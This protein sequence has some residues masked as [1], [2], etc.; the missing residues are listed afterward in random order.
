MYANAYGMSDLDLAVPNSVDTVFNLA[1]VSKQFTAFAIA[2]LEKEGKLELQ[3]DIRRY[4]PNMPE[5]DVP[6]TVADLVHHTSGLRDYITLGVLGGHDDESLIRQE[7]AVQIMERQNGVEFAAGTAYSYSNTGYVLLAEIVKAA[8]G[9]PFDD[10]MQ[11]RVFAPLGMT[12]TRVRHDLADL[13]PGYATGYMPD[14]SDNKWRRAVYNRIALGPGNVLSTVGDLAKWAGNF[15]NPRVGNSDL[16]DRLSAPARLRDGNSVNYGYGLRRE[17]IAGHN[18]VAH[19]GGIAGFNTDFAYF[20][21]LDFAVIVLANRPFPAREVAT[22]VAAIYL[23]SEESSLRGKVPDWR[24]TPKKPL[25]DLAGRYATKDGPVLTLE[26][27]QGSFRVKRLGRD[28]QQLRFWSDDSISTGQYDGVRY[29]LVTGSDGNITALETVGLSNSVNSSRQAEYLSRIEPPGTP[30]QSLLA[31]TGNYRSDE[32]DATYRLTVES[33][34]VS[35]RSLWMVGPQRMV[36]TASGRFEAETGPLQGLRF[37]AEYDSNGEC[38]ALIFR[39][40]RNGA[41]RLNRTSI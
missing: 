26:P 20:P 24:A 6:V 16:I 23:S 30:I 19:G 38:A 2:L 29:R 7:H 35:L 8:S 21:E 39:Y 5:Q 3:H 25:P 37:T 28:P 13:Q 31:L 4:L 17:T 9:I 40:G 36:E 1:S 14:D 32:I 11:Q 22:E 33:G 27:W 15:T 12:H 10:F 18:A 34:Q 41:L